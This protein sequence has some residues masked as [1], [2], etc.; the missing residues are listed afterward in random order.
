MPGKS[1]S[2]EQT[3]RALAM[4]AAGW[5]VL[6]ISQ[7]TGI[8]ERSLQ[9]I[10]SAAGTVKGEAKGELRDEAKKRLLSLVTSNDAIQ[11]QAARFI[12]DDLA[13]AA[14]LRQLALDASRHLASP[15]NLKE[16]ALVMRALAAQSTV[17]KN[18]SD[19]VR[20]S[21]QLEKRDN[22]LDELPELVITELTAED[23]EQLRLQQGE[24]DGGAALPSEEL[25]CQ[26]QDD[27]HLVDDDVVELT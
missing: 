1:H 18:T 26:A 15:T 25:L 3:S 14:H 19:M 12:A 9:R 4:R 17:L 23:V 2:P 24:Q 11:E 7:E 10:F 13:H 27:D 21:L 16:A 8:S 5:T 22:S 20:H 6:A